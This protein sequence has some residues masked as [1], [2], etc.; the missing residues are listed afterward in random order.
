MKK[1]LT[2]VIITISLLT[3]SSCFLFKPVQK[4]CPAY[5]LNH[6]E[7]SNSNNTYA[8]LNILSKEESLR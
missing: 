1:T 8:K 7:K 3:M 4:T 2:L 6:I 5:S